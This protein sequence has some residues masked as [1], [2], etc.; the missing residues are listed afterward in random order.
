MSQTPQRYPSVLVL[1]EGGTLEI[2]FPPTRCQ[3][4]LEQS[5]EPPSVALKGSTMVWGTLGEA[6]RPMPSVQ[7]LAASAAV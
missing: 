2:P 4:G 1:R 6:P 7:P 5:R 3:Q